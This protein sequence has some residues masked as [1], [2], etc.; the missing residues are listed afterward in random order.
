AHFRGPV[1]EKLVLDR[2]VVTRRECLV[3]PEL[4]AVAR[5]VGEQDRE[6]LAVGSARDR[7]EVHMAPELS[8]DVLQFHLTEQP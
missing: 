3:G 7:V 4:A 8:G 5:D 2:D 1:A 6:A